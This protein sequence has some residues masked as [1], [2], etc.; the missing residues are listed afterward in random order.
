[1][2]GGAFNSVDFGKNNNAACFLFQAS[3]QGLPTA[4]NPALGA[5]GSI[6]GF[7]AKELAP[8][9]SKFGCPALK[10]FDNSLFEAFPGANYKANGQ[11]K[12][13]L[14]GSLL[15]KLFKS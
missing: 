10:K 11:T 15:A 5:V 1:M 12:G 13:F 6:A 4:L 2:T 14:D 7:V 3:Q 8:L 9:N